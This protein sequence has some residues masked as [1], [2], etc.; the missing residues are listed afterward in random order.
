MP[1]TTNATPLGRACVR[2]GPVP[3]R[4]WVSGCVHGR[5]VGLGGGCRVGDGRGKNA[6]APVEGMDWP[7]CGWTQNAPD[8]S[9]KAQRCTKAQPPWA[10]GWAC[11]QGLGVEGRHPLCVHKEASSGATAI[12][13]CLS[14]TRARLPPHPTHGTPTNPNHATTPTHHRHKWQTRTPRRRSLPQPPPRRCQ[15]TR[16]RPAA[17]A[18]P[19]PQP[20]PQPHRPCPVPPRRR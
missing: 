10:W 3:V 20:P 19:Q 8:S 12:H 2:E 4:G 15:T 13:P 11:G 9:L 6:D 17:A 16:R 5:R 18:V 14:R 7:G 1:A